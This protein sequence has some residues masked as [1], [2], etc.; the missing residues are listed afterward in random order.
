MKI[1]RFLSVFL[2]TCLL[3]ALF[4]PQALALEDPGIR[5][6][7]AI[8]VDGET[9]TVLYDKNM[10]IILQHRIQAHQSS[11]GASGN[12]RMF[13]ILKSPVIPIDHRLELLDKP[14]H[15]LITTALEFT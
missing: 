2:L 5:A 10:M 12:E 9:G 8:L 1:R 7:A 13:S 3:C 4:T 14:A 6:K 11:H 15:G